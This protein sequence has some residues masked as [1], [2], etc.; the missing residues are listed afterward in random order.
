VSHN[1]FRS[2]KNHAKRHI[3][4]HC[5]LKNELPST[6]VVCLKHLIEDIYEAISKLSQ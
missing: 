6:G 5:L 4:K 1:K 3:T 2:S